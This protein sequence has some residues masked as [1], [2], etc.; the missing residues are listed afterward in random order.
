MTLEEYFRLPYKERE[1]ID[2]R[3]WFNALMDMVRN[4]GKIKYKFF[5]KETL[6]KTV[7]PQ[8][9]KKR[10]FYKKIKI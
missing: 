3:M 8:K 1:A 6:E 9:M 5:P 2:T 10:Q 7:A 4:M